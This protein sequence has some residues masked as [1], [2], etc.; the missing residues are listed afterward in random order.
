MKIWGR[1]TS[2]NVRKVVWAAQELGLEFE[3]IDAGMEHG[4]V[5]TVAYRAMNPNGLV[6]VIEDGG[7]VLW[8]SNTI[9]RY[10]CAKHGN[11]TLYPAGLTARFDAERW[12]DW[13]QT[14]LN[15]VSGAAFLQWFRIAPD[16]RDPQVIAASVAQ[17]E[18]LLALLDQHLASHAFMAGDH[19]TMADIPIGCEVH[20]WFNLPQDRPALP[21][22]TRWFEGIAARPAVR[23]VFDVPLR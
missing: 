8:E 10:L 16:K 13:Q 17:T 6:P 14:T 23:G 11:D 9:T 5:G 4:I 2:L 7:Y 18:P 22:L 12:M 21:H 3:R 19:F 20:R 1:L 15:R